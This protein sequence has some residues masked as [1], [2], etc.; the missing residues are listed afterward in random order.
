MTPVQFY[1]LSLLAP[2]LLPL[3]FLPFEI[4]SVF[5]IALLFGGAQYLFFA[6]VLYFVIG[7][8]KTVERIQRLARWTPV[9]FIPVQVAGWLIG[10]YLQRLSDPDLVGI[11]EPLPAFAVYVLIFGYGY[12]GLVALAYCVV[13]SRG[14]IAI[15]A[16]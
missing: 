3:P 11:W 16:L 1:R 7:R 4:G 9:L 2:I 13:R 5:V 6:A 8:L 10:A 15:N 14:H 12:V